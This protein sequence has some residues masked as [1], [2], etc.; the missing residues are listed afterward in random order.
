MQ[1][2]FTNYKKVYI[3][4][5][6]FALLLGSLYVVSVIVKRNRE[7]AVKIS[8]VNPGVTSNQDIDNSGVQNGSEAIV[9][10]FLSSET[11]LVADSVNSSSVN[12]LKDPVFQDINNDLPEKIAVAMRPFD[13]PINVEFRKV[14]LNSDLRSGR[15]FVIF[16][17]NSGKTG[18]FEF[19]YS[20]NVK[21]EWK[22]V[23]FVVGGPVLQGSKPEANP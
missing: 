18:N 4:L 1:I 5:G 20:K 6:T 17:G 21:N 19:V 16:T 2:R 22:L 10:D 3:I 9:V 13:T 8:Q 11:K 12:F 15:T 7:N 14:I 23:D